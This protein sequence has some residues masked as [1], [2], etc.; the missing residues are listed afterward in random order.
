MEIQFISWH[1]ITIISYCYTSKALILGLTSLERDL[2]FILH[3]GHFILLGGDLFL[4]LK[5]FS[6][7]KVDLMEE[8]ELG[9]QVCWTA[10][11]PGPFCLQNFQQR[12]GKSKLVKRRFV[13][14]LLIIYA[15]QTL[16]IMTLL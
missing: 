12:K 11:N 6:V 2:F 3:I 8:V 1:E 4:V 14:D 13:T 15:A 10:L 7:E 9:I 16:C 5:I